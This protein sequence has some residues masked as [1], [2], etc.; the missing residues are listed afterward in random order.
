MHIYIY[1]VTY[2]YT[3][4]Y[5]STYTYICIDVY[6]LKEPQKTVLVIT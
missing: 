3:Y 6:A 1:T 5:I 2:I 4:V